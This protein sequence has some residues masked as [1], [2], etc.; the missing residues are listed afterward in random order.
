[1]YPYNCLGLIMYQS[2]KLGNQ[3]CPKPLDTI[4]LFRSS[5]V[6]IFD[7]PP[8]TRPHR[9]LKWPP[10]STAGGAEG[11]GKARVDPLCGRAPTRWGA[12]VVA[13]VFNWSWKDT[14]GAYLT[15]T[16]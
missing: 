6:Y 13:H 4:N 10:S 12:Q 5:T 3:L 16:V 2:L 9:W 11:V 1:M 15:G 14:V 8:P 7:P